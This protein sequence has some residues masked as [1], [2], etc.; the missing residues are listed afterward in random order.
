MQTSRPVAISLPVS[1]SSF[2][3][4]WMGPQGMEGPLVRPLTLRT[5]P[6]SPTSL[7]APIHEHTISVSHTEHFPPSLAQPQASPQLQL[8]GSPASPH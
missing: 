7:T 1:G 4:E 5:T 2:S 6:M 3:W 8:T